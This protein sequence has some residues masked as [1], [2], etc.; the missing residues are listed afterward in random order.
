[1]QTLRSLFDEYDKN[2]DVHAEALNLLREVADQNSEDLTPILTASFQS[3][4]ASLR[5]AATKLLY[6]ILR[7]GSSDQYYDMALSYSILGAKAA[8]IEERTT[9]IVLLTA[10]AGQKKDIPI[11]TQAALSGCQDGHPRVRCHSLEL[12]EALVP[13]MSDELKAK[14]KEAGEKALN[15]KGTCSYASYTIPEK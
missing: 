7:M 11:I 3:E 1:M 9:S 12:L 15:D 4:H 13:M 14:A 5:I 6:N 8:N 2:K 10:L